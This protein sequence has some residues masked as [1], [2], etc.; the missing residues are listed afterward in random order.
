MR[1]Y[2]NFLLFA[3]FVFVLLQSFDFDGG[4]KRR[5][6]GTEPGY[7]GSPG[8]SFKNCTACHGGTTANVEGWVVSNIPSTG[9][10]PGQRYTITA[11]NT[12]MGATRF[13]FE[14][15]P[16]AYDGTLLGEMIITDTATTKLVGNNKYITYKAAGVDGVDSRSWSFDWIAPDS[17]VS[18]VGFYGAFNSN[19]GHKGND[20]TSLSVL[21]VWR[22]GHKS[23]I[24][25]N[26]VDTRLN[27]YPNPVNSNLSISYDQKI[28]SLSSVELYDLNGKLVKTLL[29]ET[30]VPEGVF[31]SGFDISDISAGCYILSI[32][33]KGGRIYQSVIITGK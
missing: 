16:Q 2:I 11:T 12:K 6:D 27:V 24:H 31:H 17:T 32:N 13:G 4:S 28:G 22:A 3:T 1:K 15:S 9:W 20:I 18:E 21:R 33:N 26:K 29:S 19:P 14:V 23:N 5:R 7:T 10:V 25:S 8:D 30:F